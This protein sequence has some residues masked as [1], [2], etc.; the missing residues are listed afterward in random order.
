MYYQVDGGEKKEYKIIG[1]VDS[2]G[3]IKCILYDRIK[4]KILQKGNLVIFMNYIFKIELLELI[5]IIK[6]FK[7]M[8][9]F[10][11]EVG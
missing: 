1:V 9:I 4:E 3:V 5:I 2:I 11:L 8:K 6:N 7:V 10:N